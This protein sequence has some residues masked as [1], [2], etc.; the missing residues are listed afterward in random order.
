MFD[1]ICNAI[2][3]AICLSFASVYS[4]VCVPFLFL[5]ALSRSLVNP[6]VERLFGWTCELPRPLNSCHNTVAETDLVPCSSFGS[7]ED[8][9]DFCRDGKWMKVSESGYLTSCTFSS[10]SMVLPCIRGQLFSSWLRDIR[11]FA[12]FPFKGREALVESF[13]RTALNLA[14]CIALFSQRAC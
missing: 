13:G 10:V 7:Y 3:N 2:C 14:S 6:F 1:A 8:S 12:N 9:E 11:C 4:N 5:F